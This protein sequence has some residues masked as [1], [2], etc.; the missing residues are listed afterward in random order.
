MR[1]RAI[2]LAALLVCAF[3]GV[4]QAQEAAPAAP[5]GESTAL[6]GVKVQVVISRY[7]GDKKISSLPYVLGAVVNGGKTS[8]RMGVDVPIAQTAFSTPTKDGAMSTPSTS[9]S[10]RSVG[11]NIDC[12]ATTAPQGYYKLNLTVTDSSVQLDA[13][14]AGKAL[15]PNVPMFRNFNSTFQVLLRDGQTT[16][17]TSATDPVT[18]EVTKIDVL[19]N[20]LK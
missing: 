9:Y 2:F 13:N 11:T 3:G 19:L 18:G 15:A 16:Q 17:Y 6:V 20:V 4:G 10:Y 14:N 5:R 12:Q 8:L 1:N 7:Q